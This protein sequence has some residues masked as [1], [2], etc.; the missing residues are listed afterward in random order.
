MSESWPPTLLA[1]PFEE[2]PGEPPSRRLFEVLAGHEFEDGHDTPPFDRTA[3]TSL[4]QTRLDRWRATP[5]R[6]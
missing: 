4:E 5:R 2:V 1:I 3:L 6:T